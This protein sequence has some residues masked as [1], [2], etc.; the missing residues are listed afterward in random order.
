M[1][2]DHDKD[3]AS[4][5]GIVAGV[6]S[7]SKKRLA[8]GNTSGAGDT[9]GTALMTSGNPV[10]MAAGATLKVV[11]SIANRKRQEANDRVDRE[12]DRRSKLSAALS[13]LGTGI[14]S[15]GM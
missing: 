4:E 13:Q 14:G 10:T 6:S 15:R 11:S 1:S 7:A 2:K 5:G 3:D 8:K 12:V 9:I